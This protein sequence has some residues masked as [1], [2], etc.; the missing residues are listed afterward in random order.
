MVFKFGIRIRY[1]IVAQEVILTFIV[2]V[3]IP[4]EK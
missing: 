2:N 3:Y 1:L 4:V